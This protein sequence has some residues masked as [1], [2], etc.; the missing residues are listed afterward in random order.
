[1]HQPIDPAQRYSSFWAVFAVFSALIVLQWTY[2]AA[3]L[4]E[5]SQL[6]RARVELA[7]A[8]ARARRITQTVEDLGKELLALAN[9]RNAEAARIVSELDIKLNE[10]AKER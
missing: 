8:T 5:R 2:L 3:D 6:T 1:M 4:N 9:A 10:S 7:P